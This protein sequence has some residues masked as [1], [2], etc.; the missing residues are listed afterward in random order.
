MPRSPTGQRPM[1]VLSLKSSL[2]VPHMGTS[3]LEGGPGSHLL[4]SEGNR[5]A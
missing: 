3:L 1:T 5:R 4:A 2:E